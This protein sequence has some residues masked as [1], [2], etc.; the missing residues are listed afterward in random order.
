L[1]RELAEILRTRPAATVFVTHDVA[2]LSA[3]CDRC[4]I[5]DAGEILQKGPARLVVEQPRTQRVAEILGIET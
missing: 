3:L 4:A 2:E 1:V 5:L